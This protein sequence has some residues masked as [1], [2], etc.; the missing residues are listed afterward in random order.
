MDV[1]GLL[2]GLLEGLRARPKREYSSRCREKL[3]TAL[4]VVVSGC[5]GV[6]HAY[7]RCESLCPLP[8]PAPRPCVVHGWPDD[9]VK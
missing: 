7:R 2:E 4:V 5:R 8:P 1:G 9:K 3:A 6:S